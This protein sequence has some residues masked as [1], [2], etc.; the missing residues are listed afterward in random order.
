MKR[1][2]TLRVD[3][4]DADEYAQAV[5]AIVFQN[6][7]FIADAQWTRGEEIRP[8]LMDMGHETWWGSGKVGSWLPGRE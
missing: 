3:V 8:I 4:A 5:D 1:T 6:S 7:R 2:I